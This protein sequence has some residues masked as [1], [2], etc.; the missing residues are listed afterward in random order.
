MALGAKLRGKLTDFDIVGHI[1]REISR[2]CHYFINY[3]GIIEARVRETKYRPSPIP[4]GGLEIPIRLIVKKGESSAEVFKKM[5]TKINERYCEPEKIKETKDNNI[6]ADDME[7]DL[8]CETEE[9]QLSAEP[10]I[11]LLITVKHR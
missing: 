10:S 5:E 2:F 4:S 8:I 9:E 6:L 1:P 11:D 3:G 7:E